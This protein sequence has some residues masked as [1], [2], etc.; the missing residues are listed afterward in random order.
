M[1]NFDK[2]EQKIGVCF[3][4]KSLLLEAMTHCSYLAENKSS[5]HSNERLEFLGRGVIELATSSYLLRTFPTTPANELSLIK[6][7]L[8]SANTLIGVAEELLIPRFVLMSHGEIKGNV[9]GRERIAVSTYKALTGAI[10]LD[11]PNRVYAFLN[12]TLFSRVVG[13]MGKKM[14]H[15]PKTFLQE[16]TQAFFSIAPIYKTL[17][18]SGPINKRIFTVGV[19]FGEVLIARGESTSKKAAE[20]IA[21]KSALKKRGWDIT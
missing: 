15:D 13:I 5:G 17:Q 6:N 11:Q 21:A 9:Q 1:L 10:Y 7:S 20:I 2:F 18:E 12:P 16:K 8:F 14:A 3:R 4:N 19:F